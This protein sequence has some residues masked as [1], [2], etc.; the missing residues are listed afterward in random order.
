M[1]PRRITR[2]WLDRWKGVPVPYMSSAAAYEIV[3]T[4]RGLARYMLE[5]E[6]LGK[7]CQHYRKL[8]S[9]NSA[10]YSQWFLP[11]HLESRIGSSWILVANL[12]RERYPWIRPAFILPFRWEPDSNH[13]PHLPVRLLEVA[14]DVVCRLKKEGELPSNRRWGLQPD[15]SFDLESVNL[16]EIDWD[17]ESAWVSLAAGVLLAHWQALPKA[18]IFASAGFD[19]NGAKRVEALQPKAEAILE[20]LNWEAFPH[21]SLFICESQAAELNSH[22]KAKNVA[23]LAV[24]LIPERRTKVKEALAEYLYDLEV[25]PAKDAEKERRAAYF[26]RVPDKKEAERYYEEHILPDVVRALQQKFHKRN[27]A[28]THLVSVFSFGYLVTE[29]LVAGLQVRKLLLIVADS[30]KSKPSSVEG[31][32][33]RLQSKYPH[34]EIQIHRVKM[35]TSGFPDKGE[36]LRQMQHGCNRFL[37]G[38]EPRAVAF[39]L[40][41][42]PKILTILLY[43]CCPHGAAVICLANEFDVKTRRPRPFTEVCYIWRKE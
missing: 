15:P 25:P 30:E 28:I 27:V 24:K 6:V 31:E 40:V 33:Q 42:G 4:L 35:P 11:G 20:W 38:A 21:A 41:G 23:A 22:L 36:L 1:E 26:L 2:G 34:L 43:D 37:D 10:G 3:F 39:D 16:R 17:F 18:G 13:H 8:Y 12:D 7:A 32:V 14:E 19:Q 5:P 29:L 9:E